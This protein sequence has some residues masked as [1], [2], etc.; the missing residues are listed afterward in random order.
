[1]PITIN[2]CERCGSRPWISADEYDVSIY[3]YCQGTD[4]VAYTNNQ[5][6]TVLEWNEKNPQENKDAN[7][8]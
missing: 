3:C 2:D 5:T 8:D 6:L 1:M 7:N 4:N